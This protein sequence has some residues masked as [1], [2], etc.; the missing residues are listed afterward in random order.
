MAGPEQVSP[1]VV[2]LLAPNPSPMTL[3]GTNTYI[4]GR[5]DIVVVDPGP[6]IPEHVE[7]IVQVAGRLGR[8]T[9]SAVTHHHG[10][11]LPAARR[12]RDRLG[13]P[14][15]GHPALPGVDQPLDD[16]ESIHTP[17]VELR[18][19]WTPGHTDDHVCYFLAQDAALFTGD[20]IAGRGTLIVGDGESDLSRYMASLERLLSVEARVILPGHGPAVAAPRTKVREYLDHRMERE[21]QV[22]AALEHG[23]HS[24]EEIVAA[25]Y[26]GLSD[27]L[28]PMAARN[29]RAHLY[30]LRQDGRAAES[31][32]RWRQVRGEV[33]A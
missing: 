30:K 2:R 16:G 25:V 7:A 5:G 15:A 3:D 24:V 12:L 28:V 14:I 11:H 9:R 8:L 21:R 17:K 22:L 13:V 33:G 32:A 27:A 4:V 10:D 6:D 31:N 18:V 23:T 1:N 26:P 29:V 20:L 19:L